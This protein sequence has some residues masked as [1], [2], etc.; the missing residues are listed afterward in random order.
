MRPIAVV[1]IVV[2]LGGLG[3]F[4]YWRHRE[5]DR[6]EADQAAAAKAST[7]M[8]ELNRADEEMPDKIKTALEHVVTA[9]VLSTDRARDVLDKEVMPIVDEYLGKFDAAIAAADIYLARSP[10]AETSAALDKVRG[11]AKQFHALRDRLA[12]LSAKIAAGGVTLEI[13]SQELAS[14]ATALLLPP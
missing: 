1:A 6:A 14:A 5:A 8:K 13:L 3:A 7:T 2:L 10:D 9:A 12:A 4:T 11:R